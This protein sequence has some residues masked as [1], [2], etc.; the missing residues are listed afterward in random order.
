M[1]NK[2]TQWANMSVEKRYNFLLGLIIVVLGFV[3]TKQHSDCI[4]MRREYR[5]ER[6]EI[7]GKLDDQKNQHLMYLREMDKEYRA[8]LKELNQLKNESKNN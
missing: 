3:I 5:E 6:R 8:L 4:L 1:F 2:I 7:Q